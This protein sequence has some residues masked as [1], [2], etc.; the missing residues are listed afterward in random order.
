MKF[1]PI[2]PK[3]NNTKPSLVLGTPFVFGNNETMFCKPTAVAVL[4]NGDFFVSDGYCN[5][6]IIKYDA[7]GT[8]LTSWGRSTMT[9]GKLLAFALFEFF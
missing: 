1:P 2:Y 9:K 3:N 4:D 8:Y 6:R 5:S 7:N